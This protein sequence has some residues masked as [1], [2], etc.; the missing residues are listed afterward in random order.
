MV[1]EYFPGG[2]PLDCGI[3][4]EGEPFYDDEEDEEPD[5]EVPIDAY[6]LPPQVDEDDADEVPAPQD[7]ADDTPAPEAK[8]EEPTWLGPTSGV[9][10][11]ASAPKRSH[12]D[13]SEPSV[14]KKAR[15]DKKYPLK[16]CPIALEN[17]K[18]PM[19]CWDWEE[20]FNNE[21]GYKK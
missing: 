16:R 1:R 15:V 2:F 3:D 6:L 20:A 12:E 11:F 10:L 8:K 5:E 7:D 4:L 17:D 9:P 14:V 19:G 18:L 13:S 21:M